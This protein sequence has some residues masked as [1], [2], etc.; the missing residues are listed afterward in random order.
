MEEQN[1]SVLGESLRLAYEEGRKIIS[2]KNKTDPI[3]GRFL[4]SIQVQPHEGC[5]NKEI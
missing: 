5:M 4:K 1:G 2:H 3:S